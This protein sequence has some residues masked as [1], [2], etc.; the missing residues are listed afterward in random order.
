MKFLFDANVPKK[1]Q[2]AVQSVFTKHIFVAAWEDPFSPD[3]N[4]LALFELAKDQ[5][6]DAIITH[7]IVQMVGADRRDERTRCAECGLHW[8]GIPQP[9]RV[10]GPT[11][12]SAHT[13]SGLIHALTHGI[14]IFTSSLEPTALLLKE[15]PEKIASER[16][17][18]QQ[19]AGF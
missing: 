5:G 7:D 12:K 18:P 17:Y 15:V 1:A 3:L 4:D 19:I 2:K 6:V 10:K 8:L 13:A 14:D 11:Q 9:Y 16:G